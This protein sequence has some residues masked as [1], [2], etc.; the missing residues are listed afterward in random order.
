[1]SSHMMEERLLQ[2]S[3]CQNIVR[4]CYKNLRVLYDQVPRRLDQG[5]ERCGKQHLDYGYIR[6]VTAKDL[7]ERIGVVDSE[8]F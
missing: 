6:I 2:V 1:V 7:C 3:V 4:A 5:H 8:T